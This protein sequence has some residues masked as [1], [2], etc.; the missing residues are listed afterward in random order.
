MT[1]NFCS[2]Q[3][4]NSLYRAATTL[5][6]ELRK[7]GIDSPALD[8]LYEALAVVN[9][10]RDITASDFGQAAISLAIDEFQNDDTTIDDVPFIATGETDEDGVT[11]CWVSAWLYVRVGVE[12]PV[13]A[14]VAV[15][16]L[17]PLV[18]PSAEELDAMFNPDGGGEHPGFPREEWR[19]AVANEDTISGYW[20]WVR[21]QLIEEAK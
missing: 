15:P 5:T 18:I 3:P 13:E 11:P 9:G 17:D 19:Q 8:D 20:E 21:H 4:V 12:L 14:E 1:D 2:Y 7:R 16:V 10:V 6:T